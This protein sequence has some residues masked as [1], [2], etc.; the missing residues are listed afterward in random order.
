MDK[1]RM[2]IKKSLKIPKWMLNE[3]E[4][5]EQIRKNDQ[6]LLKQRNF[7]RRNMKFYRN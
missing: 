2:E 3:E 7:L 1:Y 5:S 4:A 6:P